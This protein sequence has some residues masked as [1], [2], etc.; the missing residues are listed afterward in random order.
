MQLK[1]MMANSRVSTLCVP[2]DPGSLWAN[3]STRIVSS[4]VFKGAGTK[5]VSCD[6]YGPIS[7]G[8][9]ATLDGAQL[10]ATRF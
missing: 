9:C 10:C 5:G 8:V 4:P 3:A 7:T 2:D 1:L 6:E